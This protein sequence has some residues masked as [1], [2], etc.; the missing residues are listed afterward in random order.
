MTNRV[1]QSG[2]KPISTRDWYDFV[3]LMAD[4]LPGIHLGGRTATEQLLRLSDP[5]E[6]M[7]ILD[8]GCGGG[9]AA[10]LIAKQ[11]GARI[12]GVDLSPVMIEKARIRAKREGCSD[13]VDFRVADVYDLPFDNDAFDLI[14]LES[15]LTPLP[16]EK[17]QALGEMVRVLRQGGKIAVNESIVDPDAPEE[18]LQNIEEHPAMHGYF[19]PDTLKRFIETSGLKI[20]EWVETNQVEAPKALQEMGIKGILA[21]MVKAYPRIIARLIRDPRIRAAGK[22]DDRIT[23]A[24]ADYIGY[25]LLVAE[26]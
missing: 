13:K 16:G 3:G 10:C 24:G 15:V 11:I 23:K 18:W 12:V 6:K 14:L 4:G 1:N 8:I 25:V 22:I 17:S 7:R 2:K 20:I 26:K 21:F 9:V 5:D 19:T